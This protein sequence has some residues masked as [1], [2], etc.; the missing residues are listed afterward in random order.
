VMRSKSVGSVAF[1][2]DSLNSTFE[3]LGLAL[4]GHDK[5]LEMRHL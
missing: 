5:C 4:V 2:A 1:T 3:A